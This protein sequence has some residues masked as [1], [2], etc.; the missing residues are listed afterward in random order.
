MISSRM[1]ECIYIKYASFFID[2][3]IQ[4]FEVGDQSWSLQEF[5]GRDYG[6]FQRVSCDA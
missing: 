2:W 6:R 1:S 4:N 5:D 3:L